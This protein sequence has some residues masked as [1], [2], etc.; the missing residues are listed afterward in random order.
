MKDFVTYE[1]AKKLKEKGFRE[2]CLCRYCNYSKTLRINEVEPKI[3]RKIDYS[4]FF[5]CYNSYVDND[6]DDPTISQVLKWLREEKKIFVHIDVST[7]DKFDY[8]FTIAIQGDETW[9][10]EYVEENDYN[11]YEKASIAGIEYVLDNLI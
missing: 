9:E 11:T 7:N 8:F 5:K 2:K 1:V 10:I 4:E 6:I 3:A